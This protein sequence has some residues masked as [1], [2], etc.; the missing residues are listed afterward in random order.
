MRLEVVRL[1]DCE[2]AKLHDPGAV[3][4]PDPEKLRNC[5]I[6]GL[7]DCEAT[8]ADPRS[9]V[10]TNGS[11]CEGATNLSTGRPPTDMRGTASGR[12]ISG[13]IT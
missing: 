2:V 7:R 13:R 4:L 12:I 9:A 1:W 5:M 3:R 8:C 6:V 11:S 10:R